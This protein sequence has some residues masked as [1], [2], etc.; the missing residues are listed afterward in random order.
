MGRQPPHPAM[1]DV[2]PH[3]LLDEGVGEDFIP[4]HAQLATLTSGV[5]STQTRHLCATCVRTNRGP[6]WELPL[7]R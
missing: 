4:V 7:Q 5:F 2:H 3:G 6:S 1:S